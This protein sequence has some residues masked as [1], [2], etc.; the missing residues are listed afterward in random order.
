[1]F[2]YLCKTCYNLF[3]DQAKKALENPQN[4]KRSYNLKQLLKMLE[5]VSGS[6]NRPKKSKKESNPPEFSNPTKVELIGKILKFFILFVYTRIENY[7]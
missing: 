1:M 2:V 3:A 6:E 5:E 7:F 4:K